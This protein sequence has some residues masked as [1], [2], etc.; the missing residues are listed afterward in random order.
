MLVEQAIEQHLGSCTFLNFSGDVTI[1]WD[2]QN[3]DDIIK[4]IEKKMS[5]GYTFFTMKR[6]GI[7]RFKRKTKVTENT[8]STI[9]EVIIPDDQFDKM[10]SSVKDDDLATLILSEKAG[11]SKRD[12]KS[13][14]KAIE[15]ITDP[16]EVV[17][18]D[19]IAVKKIVGG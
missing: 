6:Q 16:K 4:I 14:L 18:K 15:K 7:L 17:K 19:T 13:D 5:E 10:L 9:E 8:L 12:K 1:V 11:L 3:K 2:E